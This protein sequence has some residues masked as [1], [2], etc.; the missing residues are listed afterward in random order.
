MNISEFRRLSSSSECTA[1]DLAQL[2]TWLEDHRVD[3]SPWDQQIYTHKSLEQLL[4]RI[5]DGEARLVWDAVKNQ[6]TIVARVA[7]VKVHAT[8]NGTLHPM[9]EFCQIFLGRE[10]TEEELNTTDPNQIISLIKSIPISG[11]RIR[12]T[13]FLWESLL[14]DED[15]KTGAMRGVSQELK[16]PLDKVMALTFTKQDEGYT[17]EE[18][19]DYPGIPSALEEVTFATVLPPELSSPVEVELEKGSILTVFLAGPKQ[20][21]VWDMIVRLLPNMQVVF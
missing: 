2:R 21:L 7:K 17:L 3:L 6:V 12:D 20:R 8:L 18:P 14:R 19:Q 11:A 1:S 10:I 5:L 16:K 4:S 13:E 9:F 15:A